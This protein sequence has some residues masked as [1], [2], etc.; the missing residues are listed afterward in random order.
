MT[1]PLFQDKPIVVE[2]D[3]QW[4]DMDSYQHVNNVIYFRYFE[5]A[6]LELIRQ[7]DWFKYE[8][9]TGIGPILASTNAKF[10]RALTYPDRISVSAAILEIKED[11]FTVEHQVVSHAQ[12]AVTTVGEG[13]VVTFDYRQ[14][15][16][17]SM[18]TELKSRL[19]GFSSSI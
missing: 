9:Q 7:L 16:K 15:K 13:V 6:R 1:H 19:I 17:V 14:G 12:N 4:G 10:I 8:E 2:L 18:P 3:V 5:N 11:R